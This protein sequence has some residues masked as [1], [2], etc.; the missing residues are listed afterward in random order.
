LETQIALDRI[1]QNFVDD[2]NGRMRCDGNRCTALV[3]A[4][5]VSVT[6]A[7]YAARPVVCRD[8]LPGDEACL[9][10]RR[11]HGMAAATIG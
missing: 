9:I 3:G 1:P 4:V 5:G 2:E 11:H 6:C 10:A 7:V 8:C